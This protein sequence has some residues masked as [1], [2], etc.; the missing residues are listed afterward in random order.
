M[1]LPPEQIS[2]K[3]RREEEPPDTLYI[4]SE[5]HQTKRRFTD[6]VFQRVQVKA[7]DLRAGHSPNPSVPA[8]P[9]QRP[10]RTPRAASTSNFPTL[11]SGGGGG[12]VPLVRATSPGAEIRDAKRLAAARR[13]QEEK[14]QRAL[15]S[16]P[17]THDTPDTKSTTSSGRGSPAPSVTPSRAVRRFQIS[18]SSSAFTP[19]RGTG[20]G[21]QKRREGGVAVLV[22]KLRREPHSRQASRVADAAAQADQPE[23]KAPSVGT[24]SQGPSAS[25]ARKRPVVN[26]AERQWRE[27][28]QTAIATAKQNISQ[29]LDQGARNQQRGDWDNE[30]DRLAVALERIALELDGGMDTAAPAPTTTQSPPPVAS[31]GPS[32]VAL[33]KPPLKYP[34]RTPNQH[35]PAPPERGAPGPDAEES[36]EDYV[37]DMYIRRP[38]AERRLTDPVADLERGRG[39]DIDPTRPDIGVIV[40][41]PEDEEYWETFATDDEDEA[42]DSEDGDSNGKAQRY[43]LPFNPR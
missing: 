32:P 22:E 12:G 15:R 23:V 2:I 31:P 20:G 10:I 38:L 16:S 5:M 42:W 30:S 43:H 41:T 33:P 28:Q 8:A 29:S 34:P 19:L 13:E 1:S 37:Y 14:L 18:R 9:S 21:V 35:R 25:R 17:I 40:I 36:D 27:Q 24:A 39:K 4:Q 6:F 11:G 3:R 26:R 7:S